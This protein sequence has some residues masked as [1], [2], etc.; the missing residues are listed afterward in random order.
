[1]RRK[2]NSKKYINDKCDEFV[3]NINR[4]DEKL[5]KLRRNKLLKQREQQINKINS[6]KKLDYIPFIGIDVGANLEAFNLKLQGWETKELLSVTT[7]GV[8]KSKAFGFDLIKMNHLINNNLNTGK[9]LQCNNDLPNNIIDLLYN[10]NEQALYLYITI[11]ARSHSPYSRDRSY[12]EHLAKYYLD[13]AISCGLPLY[14]YCEFA[15]SDMNDKFRQEFRELFEGAN[16]TVYM[17][18]IDPYNLGNNVK[19]SRDYAVCI[20]TSIKSEFIKFSFDNINKTIYKPIISN[21]ARDNKI[22]ARFFV[23]PEYMNDIRKKIEKHKFSG[24]FPEQPL[25]YYKLETGYIGFNVGY[26]WYILDIKTGLYRLP[27]PTELCI[28]MGYPMGIGKTLEGVFSDMSV[29]NA[30][31]TSPHY[32]I[33]SQVAKMLFANIVKSNGKLEQENRDILLEEITKSDR[34]KYYSSMVHKDYMQPPQKWF[35]K[36]FYKSSELRKEI[37]LF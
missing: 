20:S 29:Y 16:Y 28:L 3:K 30:F 24:H 35:S 27:T 22:D 17:D 37:R 31:A 12:K 32:S 6:G 26:C 9:L 7:N 11:Q 2:L 8:D 25:E 13:V 33:S 36:D 5:L 21:Y 34:Y 4:V 23:S 10:I 19:Y 14:I 15:G 18:N 1:M